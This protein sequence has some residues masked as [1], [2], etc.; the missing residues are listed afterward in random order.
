[1]SSP[2]VSIPGV[3]NVQ[4]PSSMSQDDINTAAH[5]LYTNAASQQISANPPSV[6]APTPTDLQG[7]SNNNY[8]SVPSE[9][10][11]AGNDAAADARTGDDPISQLAAGFDK[12][13][14]QSIENTVGKL[15]P[16]QAPD[17]AALTPNGGY[18]D[19][20]ALGESVLEAIAADEG[21]KSL[22]VIEKIKSLGTV[23]DLMSKHPL[24]A[25]A[26]GSGLLNATSGAITQG[27]KTGTAEGAEEG[28]IAG[29]VAGAALPLAGAAASNVKSLASDVWSTA[30]GKAI[31]SD[32]QGGIRSVLGDAADTAEVDIPSTASI[33]TSASSL[34]DNVEAKSKGIFQTIDDATNGEATN[35]QS[36]IRNVDNKLRITAGTD[37]DLEEKLTSQKTAL[38]SRFNDVLDSAKENGVSQDTI[39]TA[40]QTW[41]QSSAL[42]DL[43]TQIKASTAG[44]VKNAPEVVDPNKLVPRLQKL[45]D[46]GRLE[47]ALGP[48]ADDLLQTVYDSQKATANRSGKIKAAK[49]VGGGVGLTTSGGA[50]GHFLAGREL[51]K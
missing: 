26:L 10:T 14:G 17:K 3:G 47:E 34:A 18:Q 2:V 35:L 38:E 30:T 45:A 4:F 44:N 29:G 39:D 21:F 8:Q 43:D 7:P 16:G 36:K 24:I 31:Q 6:Q 5:K 40:K 1:M 42:R 33:R 28:A 20:G 48:H 32:L 23:S 37:D 27:V 12:S 50:L 25:K 15:L 46:S 13:A 9:Q 49:Y 41:K 11:A 22:G 51:N 19:A